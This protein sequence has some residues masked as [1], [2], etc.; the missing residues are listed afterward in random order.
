[1]NKNLYLTEG[2]IKSGILKFAIPIL[3]GQL[4]QQLYNAAD[5][6]V[7]GNFLGQIALGSVASTGSIIFLLVGFFGGV[8][9][10]IGVVISK[11]FGAGK[12]ESVKKAVGTSICFGIIA[13]IILTIIGVIA[14]PYILQL[15]DTPI[16][17]LPDSQ[18]Y[19]KTYF[20]GVSSLILYNT[21]CGIF[22]AI[23]D[24]KR[25]LCYLIISSII[26]IFLDLFLVGYIGM[27]VEGAAI[28]TVISQSISAI[29]A[30][31]RLFRITEVYKVSLDIIKIDFSILKQMISI[32]IPSGFQNSLIAVGNI[33]VQS[34]INSFGATIVAGNGSYTKV[35]GFMFIPV[36]AFS[37]SLTT[38]VSQNIGAGKIDRV[39]KGAKFG[40][41]I[42]CIC[43]QIIGIVF[44]IY[45]SNILS[46]FGDDFAV[47][48]AGAHRA[49]IVTL[50]YILL[51]Y[52]HCISG[53]LRGAGR[54]KTPMFVMISTWCVFRVVFVEIIISITNNLSLVYVGYPL[55]WLVSS[56]VFAIYYKKINWQN[57]CK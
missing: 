29:L 13:S 22:Q 15:M 25:P 14:T 52:S 48:T 35:E 32:G 39:L 11:Y 3:V 2:N 31:N 20:A 55:S 30:F 37:M 4:F 47:I 21:A 45:K 26:N 46:L 56:I 6:I 28:A 16:E 10:G 19:V 41:I 49:S 33:L 27:G 23:G 36:T 40:I 34:S 51:A 8:S 12:T 43:T 18:K 44:F 54:S 5:A 7:V 57:L 42:G 38:F 24:S 50:F 9:T 17:L 53:V 1:M